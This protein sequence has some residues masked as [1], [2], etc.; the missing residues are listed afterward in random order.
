MIESVLPM[1]LLVTRTPAY[2][3]PDAEKA[4][5]TLYQLRK[6]TAQPDKWALLG[7]Y[8]RLEKGEIGQVI[9]VLFHPR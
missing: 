2:C 5:K 4:L 3:Q 8:F 9:A 7:K 1:P 6:F